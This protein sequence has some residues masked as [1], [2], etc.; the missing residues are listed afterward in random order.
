MH[1]VEVDVVGFEILQRR[2]D[3]LLDPLVPWVIQLGG[4]PDLATRN[5]R[6]DNALSD[7]GLISVRKRAEELVRGMKV[8]AGYTRV[9]M[10][11]AGL[12]SNFDSLTDLI[13]SGLP[14][15]QANTGHASAAIKRKDGSRAKV[16]KRSPLFFDS[17]MTDLVPLPA[18]EGLPILV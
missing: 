17:G 9:D 6:V 14:S 4:E 18:T 10:S 5:A 15:S 11:V 13:G 12:Q 7:F 3:A 16:N 2:L 8:R 1:E